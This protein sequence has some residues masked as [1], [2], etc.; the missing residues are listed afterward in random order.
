MDSLMIAS[1]IILSIIAIFLIGAICMQEGTKG[2]MNAFTGDAQERLGKNFGRTI[3][4]KLS[5]LTKYA[6]VVFF[7][8][9]LAVTILAKNSVL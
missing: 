2:G 8:I 7:I 1:A 9:T 6:A 4:A 3:D 5:K